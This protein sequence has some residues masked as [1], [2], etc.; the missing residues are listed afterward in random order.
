MRDEK[1]LKFIADSFT[2]ETCKRDI[3]LLKDFTTWELLNLKVPTASYR[4]T[5][6]SYLLR[7]L[8]VSRGGAE[9]YGTILL[10]TYLSSFLRFWLYLH[11]L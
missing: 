8:V 4:I 10:Y 9:L 5:I 1:A 2:V 11:S 7:I 3:K 6:L